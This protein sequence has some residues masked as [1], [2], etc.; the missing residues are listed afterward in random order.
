MAL[1][2][3]VYIYSVKAYYV[4]DE[5]SY[6][7]GA[8]NE[9]GKSVTAVKGY[10]DR[11]YTPEEIVDLYHKVFEEVNL[12]LIPGALD[13]TVKCES[14]EFGVIEPGL[15]YEGALEFA[16]TVRKGGCSGAYAEYRETLENGSY[17]IYFYLN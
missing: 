9:T 8:Y 3:L 16:E 11:A 2:F 5:G 7:Y 15:T 13:G 14:C 6:V 10:L 12:T 1:S 17:S 4:N